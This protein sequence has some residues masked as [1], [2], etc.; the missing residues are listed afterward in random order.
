MGVR[1]L[2]ASFSAMLTV[3]MS[4]RGDRGLM[5]IHFAPLRWVILPVLMNGMAILVSLCSRSRI[6]IAM[7][8]ILLALIHGPLGYLK[9]TPGRKEEAGPKVRRT[10]SPGKEP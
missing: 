5:F 3:R 7:H 8:V 9:K 4:Q 2:C 6:S 1:H 10:K